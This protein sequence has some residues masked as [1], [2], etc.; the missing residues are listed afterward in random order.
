V[1]QLHEFLAKVLSRSEDRP[2]HCS[3][4]VSSKRLDREVVNDARSLEIRN[5]PDESRPRFLT[6][7]RKCEHDGLRGVAPREMKD[8]I[9]RCVVA[10]VHVL[11]REEY[12][13]RSREQGHDLAECVKQSSPVQFGIDRRVWSR[14]GKKRPELGEYRDKRTCRWSQDMRNERWRGRRRE[15]SNEIEERGVWYRPLGL[16][17]GAVQDEEARG[18]S[19]FDHCAQKTRFADTRFADDYGDAA[20]A[21]LST[22]QDSTRRGELE[23][24]ADQGWT[25][26][27][28][29]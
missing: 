8:E 11:E 13:L 10:P 17:T 29:V 7:I 3:N 15:Q 2:Q 20:L 14:V 9:E 4:I 6:P 25:D 26:D 19:F 18:A 5:Q 28:V 27:V 16:E 1:Q 24:A 21:I 23:V 22:R 12:R